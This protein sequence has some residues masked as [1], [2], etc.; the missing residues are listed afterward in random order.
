MHLL[1]LNR[2]PPTPI[3]HACRAWLLPVLRIL[4]FLVPSMRRTGVS[5]G[6][7]MQRHACQPA[8]QR[9]MESV[10]G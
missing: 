8:N 7:V 5:A 2:C 3:P 6:T 4:I 10:N 1:T 9:L